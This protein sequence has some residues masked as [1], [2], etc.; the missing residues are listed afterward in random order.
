MGV[1][2]RVRALC[3]FLQDDEQSPLRRHTPAGADPD[4]VID[5]RAVFQQPHQSLDVNSMPALLQPRKGR[6]GLKDYE[7]VFCADSREGQDI[8]ALRGIDR[9]QGCIIIV[10]PDQ[11]VADVLPL[12]DHA[13]LTQFFAGVLRA[14]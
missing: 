13:R 7:K 1:D 5:V 2:C 10:R 9:E 3:G 6:Y 12:D 14:V 4:A 11:Y 8:Y